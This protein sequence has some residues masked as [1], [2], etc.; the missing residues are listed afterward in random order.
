MTRR[1]D[2]ANTTGLRETRAMAL[3]LCCQRRGFRRTSR[4]AGWKRQFRPFKGSWTTMTAAKASI[5]SHGSKAP[6]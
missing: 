5:F 4:G 1:Q 2:E 6:L 3:H